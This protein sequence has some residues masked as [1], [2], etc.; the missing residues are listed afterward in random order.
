ML[1]FRRPSVITLVTTI[2]TRRVITRLSRCLSHPLKQWRRMMVSS[3]LWSSP[4][5]RIREH[6]SWFWMQRPSRSWGEPRSLL[7]FLTVSTEPSMLTSESSAWDDQQCQWAWDDQ[8]CQ[9]QTALDDQQ[10]QHPPPTLT[11]QHKDNQC[12]NVLVHW[13]WCQGALSCHTMK[14]I[15]RKEMQY[16]VSSVMPLLIIS[17]DFYYCVYAVDDWF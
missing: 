15:K 2:I 14:D 17:K 13:G 11:V 12:L 6:F 8:Q 9:H 16:Y 7:T 3:C 1:K 4:L 5:H 10:C